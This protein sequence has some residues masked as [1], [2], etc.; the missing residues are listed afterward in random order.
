M[1]VHIRRCLSSIAIL[2][3]AALFCNFFISLIFESGRLPKSVFE[4]IFESQLLGGLNL[5][6][7]KE[8]EELTKT[9]TAVF[10]G[11]LGQNNTELKWESADSVREFSIKKR[12]LWPKVKI[13]ISGCNSEDLLANPTFKQERFQPISSDRTDVFLFSAYSDHRHEG[14]VKVIG[15]GHKGDRGQ[16]TCRW[17]Y[18]HINGNTTQL[19]AESVKEGQVNEI[20]IT[21]F[22][23]NKGWSYSLPSEQDTL[24]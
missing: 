15:I 23:Y 16:I 14:N 20:E 9:G 22:Q 5:T 11:K 10:L 17:Y 6:G 8:H 2:L 24:Y 7:I 13:N 1:R 21:E 19:E 12:N 18:G 4:S 3:L